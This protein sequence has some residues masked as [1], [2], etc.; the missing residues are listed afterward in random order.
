MP[1]DED[2]EVDAGTGAAQTGAACLFQ[3]VPRPVTKVEG[4]VSGVHNR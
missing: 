2:V 1:E 3:Q 4:L